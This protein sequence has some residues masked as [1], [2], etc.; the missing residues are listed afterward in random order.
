M[1]QKEAPRRWTRKTQA[2][3]PARR[4]GHHD[5]SNRRTPNGAFGGLLGL[6]LSQGLIRV[7]PHLPMIGPF[8]QGLAGFGLKP[9]LAF[10]GLGLALFIAL[11]AGLVPAVLAYRARITDLL[12]QV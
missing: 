6:V 8:V 10:A 11:V 3:A 9:P 2:V 7:L 4:R 5:L 1:W 12:R